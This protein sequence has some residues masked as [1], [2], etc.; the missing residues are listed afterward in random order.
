M[1]WVRQSLCKDLSTVSVISW[2][3]LE[4]PHSQELWQCCVVSHGCSVNKHN[5]WSPVT[6]WMAWRGLTAGHAHMP[7]IH[8]SLYTFKWIPKYGHL[9]NNTFESKYW[10]EVFLCMCMNVVPF[11]SC[12]CK[13]NSNPNYI[14]DNLVKYNLVCNY[15]KL[16]TQAEKPRNSGWL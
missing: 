2:T 4:N 14:N 5:T 7:T 3:Q 10:Q 8:F 9:Y 1:H 11:I 16:L 15:L 12:E 6:M 13:H